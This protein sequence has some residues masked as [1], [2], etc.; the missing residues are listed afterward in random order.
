M[1][2]KMKDG[3]LGP[4]EMQSTLFRPLGMSCP[5]VSSI[6]IGW[7]YLVCLRWSGLH[8]MRLLFHRGIVTFE[9]LVGN[10]CR[11]PGS[12]V[13]LNASVVRR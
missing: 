8:R 9:G 2:F 4:T 13:V 10:T 1:V 12:V 11:T 7:L 5:V 6:E 3:R